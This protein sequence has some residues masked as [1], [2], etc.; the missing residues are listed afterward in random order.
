MAVG[1]RAW[2][3]LMRR[4]L[5][6]RRR[7]WIGTIL[8]ILLP[9]GF[10]GVLVGI[11]VASQDT[12][13][14]AATTVPPYLPTNEKAFVPLSFQ[15]YVT[16]MQ[17]QRVCYTDAATSVMEITGLPSGGYNWQVPFVKCDPR[18]CTFD[19]ED[20]TKYCEFMRLG[21]SG[22][23]AGGLQRAR[24]FR[25]WLYS[26]YPAVTD[27]AK[28]PFD[29]EL[30]VM[31][32]SSS[33]MD[34]Y[35]QSGDY[36]TT[37]DTP[38]LALGI[39]FD[40]DS[41]TELS[42]SLRQ[43]STN[44]NSPQV[45]RP[46][47]FTT[48]PTNKLFNDYA[49][50]DDDSCML[51]GGTAVLGPLEGSCTGQYVYNGVLTMQR[52]VHDFFM[53][54]SGAK[55]QGYFVS[56][57][58]VA[59][60]QFP[61][62]QYIKNGFYASVSGYG[63]L[64]VTLGLLYPVAA[65]IMYVVREKEL[66]QKELMKMMSVTESDIGWAWFVTFYSVA[67]LTA[68]ASAGVSMSLYENS[69]FLPLWIFW[70]LVFLSVTVFSMA[71]AAFTAK[72][73]RAVLIGLLVFFI[74]VFLTL[75][76]SY[77]TGS[78]GAVGIISLHPVAALSYGLQEIGALEDRG[79]GLTANTINQTDNPSGYT[80]VTALS[81]L[82]LDSVLW[83]FLCFYLNRVI[84]P[85]YGQAL[86]PW[87][88]FQPRYWCPSRAAASHSDTDDVDD[89]AAIPYE[90]VGDNFQRQTDENKTIEIHR[91]RKSF[92]DKTAVD[93]VTLSM[94]SGQITA[95]LGHNGAG[96]TTTIGCLTGALD[97][98]EGYATIF[99]KDT[100]T[101][102][103][104]IRQDIGICL[105][106]DCLFPMLTVREHLQFFS[107]VKGLY[108]QLSYAEAEEQIDQAIQDVALSEKRNIMSKNLSGGMKRKLS[109]AIAFCGGSKVVVLDEPTSGMDPFARR[110]CW[111]VI[112][113]YRQNRC[114]LLTTHFM[115]EADILGDRIAIMAEGQLRCCGSSLFLKKTY[116]VGYCLTIERFGSNAHKQTEPAKI[117]SA[118]ASE[119]ETV[120]AGN[121]IEDCDTTDN[122]SVEQV[123][124][125]AVEEA[126]LLS[127]VGSEISYQLPLGASS[128]FPPMF[129]SLDRLVDDKAI[130]SYGVSL[131]T[132]E[133]VFLLVARGG[134]EEK[135]D[136]TSSGRPAVQ[137]L[138]K[139]PEK[140][141]RSQMDLAKEGLFFTHLGALFK[142]RA[143]SFRRDKKAWC[144]TTIV[145]SIFV[146]VGLIVFKFASPVR[147]LEPLYLSLDEYNPGISAPPRNPI[148]FNSPDAPFDCQPG[149]CAYQPAVFDVNQT[150]EQYFLCGYQGRFTSQE[151]CSISDTVNIMDEITGDGAF[152]GAVLVETIDEAS[153]SLSATADQF[154]ASKYGAVFFAHEPG[155]T[156]DSGD[157]YNVT[158]LSHCSN[159]SNDYASSDECSNLAGGFGY[160][161]QYN[162]T[163]LHSA[164]L[165]QILADEALAREALDSPNV[166][167]DCTIAPLP[168]TKSESSNRDADDAFSAWFLVILSFPFIAGAFATF[169]VNERQSKAKHL[170][171]VAGVEPSSYWL[172]TYLWDVLNY[173]IPLWI[174]VA[175][176]F[177]F[178]VDVF[179]KTEKD[180][181]YG[182]L[183]L[184]I[185][186][187][188]A[189]AGFT[190][191]VSF[192]FSS[193]SLCNVF[194]I[195]SGFLIGMGGPLASFILTLIG[196]DPGAPKQDLIDAANILKWIL[197]FF[198]TFNLGQGLFAVLNLETIA[199]LEGN[200]VTTVFS[201]PVMLYEII[202]LAWESIIYVAL[203]IQ[204]DKW[205]TNPRV[206]S[207][208][209]MLLRFITCRC[210]GRRQSGDDITMAI[211][212][213][214]DVMAEQERVLLGQANDDK[215]VLSQLTKTYDGGK[216]AVNNL[217][218][219]IAPGECFG[220][221]GINGAGKTTT[222]GILTAEFPPS[223]G[224]ATLA[225]HSVCRE[226]EKIRRRIGYC[227]QF[228]AHF[229]NLTGREHVE[230]YA[231]IKG[232]PRQ[233][234]KEAA[235]A[236]LAEVGL[237]VKDADRL[238][239]GYSGGMKRRLS[240]ACATIGQPAIVFLDECS[241]G[242]DPVARREI[243]ALISEM[244]AGGDFPEEE[245]TSV[246]LTTH[247]M[248]KCEAL[249]PRIAIMANGRLRCLG[250]AQ[251]LKSKFGQ[252]YQVELKVR[253]T[254]KDDPDCIANA[255]A[256]V[257]SKTGAA[258]ADIE[259]AF[260]VFFTLD[261]T[262]TALR[263]LSGDETLASAVNSEDPLGY[264]L[265]KDA[266]SPTGA[267]LDDIAAFATTELRM[268][269]LARFIDEHYPDN[270]LRERQDNKV[271]YEIDSK[272][273]RIASIFSTIEENKED[274][275]L[276][277]YGASQTSLEQVFNMHAAE[278]EKLKQGRNER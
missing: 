2:F 27:S 265:W 60:V 184:L 70:I 251:H 113:Q 22:S 97:A 143:A 105:Q 122:E 148:V 41:L 5:V 118:T 185:L 128:K 269:K 241:T 91:L 127:N 246:I 160:T 98:T 116:G 45:T 186:F 68:S 92:G 227:P 236:K 229:E 239:S 63:P 38:K 26:E 150:G 142:K 212:D 278:A 81:Y 179:I 240:L 254:K 139:D 19:G 48:P 95:L 198:P 259:T 107:R 102:M 17:A 168:I 167:I 9:V 243:W 51:E 10:I 266:S 183:I 217:S 135:Q 274:L 222:M 114:I 44:Y 23:D 34:A 55:E 133:E 4:N 249:C 90:P 205:S 173:Q 235:A 94:Y 75:A 244:V 153:A 201:E 121:A 193:P 111:N 78:S 40:G 66:R 99:G 268:R 7:N 64:L 16:T 267:P 225:G 234:I 216:L 257:K 210:F 115:D 43:N 270:I 238:S 180:V 126:V 277:E 103:N 137:S 213:D 194:I 32:D 176:I 276:S 131:T 177:A 155:S 84:R 79:V 245:R 14:F 253:L 134:S 42:Y 110:F 191:C 117:N 87:F 138:S 53:D 13:G 35:V 218:F 220:L 39:V 256:L 228:D 11:K 83:G 24:N 247:S 54:I 275:M 149:V 166:T 3:A 123:I 151:L 120:A 199:F 85:D 132:L 223:S 200:D 192:A 36:G 262:L 77:E 1:T 181:V 6:Y 170:Q 12:T 188:P 255:A 233:F 221:L 230:L 119:A 65:M 76:V 129:E 136:F 71:V 46:A 100:R 146:L 161:I 96:K 159:A 28:V 272:N 164:P 58:G 69:E 125:K 163:A 156:I 20:A 226:P 56:Q 260:E 231:S 158:V 271:R 49:K 206:L 8:E 109:L 196:T 175:L 101:Q 263:A 204:L 203:A 189:A 86:P 248:A 273:V 219:G 74:G 144:C 157:F 264:N 252:G 195:I 224:D 197:R 147:D 52:L 21:L 215:I 250:S 88:I 29:S 232:I 112:R 37:E 145:P 89:N 33:D 242:V 72:T 214:D 80:F 31:F 152:A 140:S 30:V 82:A 104:Q 93:G 174:T 261:E 211:P 258:P 15:D 165:F 171:T 207:Y 130:S 25:N 182:V 190:Y 62:P 59:F 237:S 202:F 172:S 187:G 162:F 178:G 73:V 108:G 209:N 47:M 124:E 57:N 106:H 18:Q 208:W 67:F 141:H 154:A 169:I 50:N 61:T